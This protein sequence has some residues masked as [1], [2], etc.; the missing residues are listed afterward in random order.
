ML[1]CR[2]HLL[3][4]QEQWSKTQSI[5]LLPC[6][7]FSLSFPSLFPLFSLSFPFSKKNKTP[8]SLAAA[9]SQQSDLRDELRRER[10][11]RNRWA[12]TIAPRAGKLKTSLDKKER[13]EKE[14]KNKGENKERRGKAEKERSEETTQKESCDDCKTCTMNVNTWKVLRD[15]QQG[16]A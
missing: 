11:K 10:E 13:K 4:Q 1:P 7:L 9:R 3:P 12:P 14:K 6:S 8:C 16:K 5:F 2:D 15:L